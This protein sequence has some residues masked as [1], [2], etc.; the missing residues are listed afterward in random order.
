M[1]I[2]AAVAIGLNPFAAT[3]VLAALAAFT[4]RVPR[5]AL[6][7]AVPAEALGAIAIV[8]GLAMPLDFVLAKFVG[9]APHVRRVSQFAAPVSGALF[10][11]GLTRSDVPLPLVVAGTAVLAWLVAAMVTAAAARASRSPAWVGLGHIPVLMAAATAAACIVPLGLAR[12]PL[13]LG[14]A[15]VSVTALSWSTLAGWRPARR[16]AR[17][18]APRANRP[19]PAGAGAA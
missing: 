17:P 3:F 15:A 14:L 8:A 10:A 7:E 19:R 16:A 12:T 9:A 13:G 6:L 2:L 4:A 1:E 18:A 11:A 5:G